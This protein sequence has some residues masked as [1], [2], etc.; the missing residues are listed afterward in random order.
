MEAGKW[1]ITQ[2]MKDAWGFA[3]SVDK[4]VATANAYR[5]P[6][7]AAQ[8][9]GGADKA[10]QGALGRLQAWPAHA[11]SQDAPLREDHTRVDSIELKRRYSFRCRLSCIQAPECRCKLSKKKKK[12]TQ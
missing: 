9:S 11:G 1:P 8:A 5:V 7:G 12:K 10:H 2:L 6:A 3:A 4:I